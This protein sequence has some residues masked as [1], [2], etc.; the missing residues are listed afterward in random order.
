MTGRYSREG[1]KSQLYIE[2]CQS[3]AKI[4][5]RD[6]KAGPWGPRRLRG[7]ANFSKWLSPPPHLLLFWWLFMN[8]LI[9]ACRCISTNFTHRVNHPGLQCTMLGLVICKGEIKVSGKEWKWD[10]WS[11]SA[12]LWALLCQN[13]PHFVI[14]LSLRAMEKEFN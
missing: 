1:L 12:S 2:S 3:E 9:V 5:R 14:T 13:R 7:K 8:I 4:R 6:M 11:N 10:L